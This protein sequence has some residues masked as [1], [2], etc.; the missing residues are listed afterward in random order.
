MG[1]RAKNISNMP[2]VNQILMNLVVNAKDALPK[3]GTLT[4]ETS[5]VEVDATLAATHRGLVPGEYVLL[6]VEDSG[7]GMDA[8]TAQ[9]IFEPFFTTKAPGEGVGLG[10]S[11]VYG[12]INQNGGWIEVQ[13]EPGRGTTFRIYW[14]KAPRSLISA[15]AVRSIP[16]L[17]PGSETILL[18]EDQE[19]VR[20]IAHNVLSRCG[21]QVLSCADG[22]SALQLASAHN[23]PIDMLV[24]DV[25]MPGMS[26]PELATRLKPVRPSCK[27]LYMS[28]YSGDAIA[29]RGV[30]EARIGYL[31][32]PF[33]A[34]ELSSKVREV[35]DSAAL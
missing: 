32:K 30:L 24:T 35:L 14:P 19:Q 11:T 4:I 2:Q 28:G 6:R 27:V 9:H 25:V 18:V 34:A 8:N 7:T 22:L 31:A 16:T 29:R 20:T 13:T 3:G 26:G 33:S 17:L 5:D 10:L 1:E 12:I 15:E 23:G 21:Y